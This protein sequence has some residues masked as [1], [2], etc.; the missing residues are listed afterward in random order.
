M[1]LIVNPDS[2]TAFKRVVNTPRR[3]IGDSSLA[4][5]LGIAESRGVSGYD[6]LRYYDQELELPLRKR[7]SSFTDTMA[8]IELA[9]QDKGVASL[10]E[11]ILEITG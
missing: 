3:G 1:T 8:A 2:N 4:K 10:I 5:V 6:M 9:S 11:D 7:F